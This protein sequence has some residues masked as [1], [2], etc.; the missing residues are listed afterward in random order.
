MRWYHV[1]H[2]I[3]D[4]NRTQSLSAKPEYA[5]TREVK[6]KKSLLVPFIFKYLSF[7]NG[8]E[9]SIMKGDGLQLIYLAN[10]E[11]G[12]APLN[13]NMGLISSTFFQSL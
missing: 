12:L 4:T 5:Q 8:Q 6:K 13:T 7:L 1:L 10:T 2:D 9:N 11:E 3:L